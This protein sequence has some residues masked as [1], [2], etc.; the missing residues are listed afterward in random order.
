MSASRIY[1]CFP[2]SPT[3]TGQGGTDDPLLA[4][5]RKVVLC[6][7]GKYYTTLGIVL[8]RVMEYTS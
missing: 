4:R 5:P 3:P 2:P 8:N 1:L 7:S 6:G